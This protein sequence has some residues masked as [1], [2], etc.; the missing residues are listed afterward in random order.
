MLLSFSILGISRDLKSKHTI[1]HVCVVKMKSGKFLPE[2]SDL[3]GLRAA[4]APAVASV[5]NMFERQELSACAQMAAIIW[6]R[7][8]H[9]EKKKINP[10]FSVHLFFLSNY[11]VLGSR[12]GGWWAF[13][14]VPGRRTARK[15]CK[16]P[17]DLYGHIK[18]FSNGVILLCVFTSKMQVFPDWAR[19]PGAITQELV[20]GE[21]DCCRSPADIAYISLSAVGPLAAAVIHHL[22]R[23]PERLHICMI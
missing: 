14:L 6:T 5:F 8:S 20:P 7:R 4:A 18:H 22:A 2:F 17:I 15:R 21:A 13:V 9:G 12:A 10:S 23:Q 11:W 1:L 16:T 19:D 3:S